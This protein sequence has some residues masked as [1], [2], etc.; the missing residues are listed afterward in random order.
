MV[1]NVLRGL[2]FQT[3]GIIAAVFLLVVDLVLLGIANQRFNRA[4]LILDQS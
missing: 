2:D 3:I 4:R 1:T